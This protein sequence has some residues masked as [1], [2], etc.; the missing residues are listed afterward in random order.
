MKTKLLI[1]SALLAWPAAAGAGSFS[2]AAPLTIGRNELA[3]VG[4][5]RVGWQSYGGP[6][7]WLPVGWAGGQD[8]ASG[9][10]LSDLGPHAGRP[11]FLL[12]CPWRVPPGRAWM[13]Y[14]LALP[15]GQSARLT[16]AVALHPEAVLSNRSDGV[17][18][19]CVVL[20]AGRERE[21]WREHYA[22]TD[23]REVGVNLG[24]FAGQTIALR[25]QVEPGPKNHTAWDHSLIGQPVV[26]VGGAAPAGEAR[27]APAPRLSKALQAT[28]GASR[29][30]V[31]NQPT[32]GVLPSNLLP[33]RNRLAAVAPRAGQSPAA[34]RVWE[35]RYEG[36]D[37]RVVYSY[38]PETGTLDDFTVRVDDA[39]AF[40]PAFGGGVFLTAERRAAE[41]P[42]RGARCVEVRREGD[43][44]RV[45]WE[46][47]G[48]GRPVPVAW[49]FRIQG[50]ALVVSAECAEPAVR[51]FSLGQPL[52]A[53][54]RRLNVPYLPGPVDFLPAEQLFACRHLNWTESHASRCPQDEAA[55]EPKTDGTRNP[56]RE[57][58]YVAVSPTFEEVLPNIP[59]PPSP[60]LAALGPNI[61]L[62]IW[63]HHQGTYAGDA[64]KLRE[65]KDH[66]VDHLVIIQH[67]WQ[68][69]GYDVKL[70]DHLPANPRYGGDEGLKLFGRTARECGY[71]W[72]LHENYI[73]LY[74]DAPSY[75]PAARVLN[76]DGSPSQAWF[77]PATQVQS[78]GLKCNR[79]LGFARQNSPE[80]HARYDTTAAY[81]DVHTCVPPWHQLDHEAGQPMAAM[82][83]HKVRRDAELFQF[84]RDTHGGPLFG[85]GANHFYWAGLC[86]G[87]EAQVNGG[88][89][90]VPLPDFDLLK[91]HPQMVNHGM[92]YY[93]RWFRRGYA[94]QWGRDAGSLAQL[95]QYRAMQIAYGHAGFLG[96]RLVHHLPSVVREHHLMHPVQ[97]LYGSARPVEI[98]HEVGG[99]LVSVSVA[100][101]AG[102]TTRQR[103]RYDSGLTVWVNGRAE[104]WRIPVPKS[105]LQRSQAGKASGGVLASILDRSRPC[106]LPQWGWLALGPETL[107][108]TMLL[109]GR[110]ADYAECPEYVFAD[111][112]TFV[113]Q[114]WHRPPKDIEPRLRRLEHLGGDRV[115]VTYEWR[116]NDTL[117]EDY[118]C[119]VHF[120]NRAA[121]GAE[122]IAFQQDHALP[123]PTR[124]WRKGDLIVDG[125]HEFRVPA[126][127]AT[128][129]LVLGL[130]KG[131]R[132][133]LRGYDDGLTRIHLAQVRVATRGGQVV[134]VASGP[135]AHARPG[136]TRVA[137]ADFAA[138]RNPPGAWLDFG[139]V[140]TDGAVKI[141]REA[142]RLVIFPYPREQQF[143]LSLDVKA[144]APAAE[145]SRLRVRAL[146]AGNQSD[147]GP[148]QFKVERDRL[149]LT[150]GQPGVARWVVEW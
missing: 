27:A 67:D 75:D 58:G 59:H 130:H 41:T 3:D 86:D 129:D 106:L 56:L 98:R 117:E 133:R 63:S 5:A 78:W 113:D 8:E 55:Y 30:A 31:C 42:A 143:R 35:F 48:V 83:L 99:Q 149:W 24:E 10:S 142:G 119:F 53:A 73:D 148:A 57:T 16:F 6:T 14:P 17:T 76:A 121:G 36:K 146:A 125:P 95:D 60:F 118:Q 74:P 81:L 46:Y 13:E 135:A 127:N 111:A 147:L 45:R 114:P 101:A 40:Q 88:E 54:R 138:H 144:L 97:R 107:A 102:D 9:V 109:D 61:M 132:L 100:L 96:T 124:Q 72:S 34:G 47:E 20:R 150:A 44:L 134:E 82:A 139:S 141:H 77:N 1:L 25:L 69:F 70:P 87:V 122:N 65:L 7:N 19:S 68:H 93:E 22:G 104:T 62:D 64:A 89:D 51:R 50:K 43:T 128:Y 145:V 105:E 84:E 116:V 120:L 123:K 23:W 29:L 103:I 21:L 37:C 126:T 108:G 92:G 2:L 4:F 32:N 71:V 90:H 112:R 26:E 66:G 140:A 38:S 12:H 39:P 91:L 33:F 85:E 18:F 94:A 110:F 136:A 79:A 131:A 52:A 15:A 115:R 137:E 11:A 49:G 80:A 28:D